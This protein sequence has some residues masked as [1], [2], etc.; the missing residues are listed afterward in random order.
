MLPLKFR[1][2]PD[3]FSRKTRG[4]RFGALGRLGPLFGRD[5]VVG[6]LPFLRLE[7]VPLSA[8]LLRFRVWGFSVFGF[9]VE[10]GNA[11]SYRAPAF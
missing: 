9:G 4:E 3:S 1:L 8:V 2:A 10:G 5:P 6:L 11:T 7:I